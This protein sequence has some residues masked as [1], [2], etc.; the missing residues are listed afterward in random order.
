M[1]R[2][3]SLG[4]VVAERICDLRR[5]GRR[6]GRVTV[7]LGRPVRAPDAGPQDP[8]WCIVRLSG[9]G[10]E[11]ERPIAG[12]DSLQAL[13]LALEFA[14]DILPHEA[15]GLG[16]R[17]DWLAQPERLVLAKQGMAA[18]DGSGFIAL[19]DQISDKPA[20]A[21]TPVT[22]SAQPASPPTN[23]GSRPARRLHAVAAT[24]SSPPDGPRPPS[25][26]PR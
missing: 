24:D 3:Q 18:A 5:G 4:E 12:A 14:A 21:L 26:R 17:L 11:L 8:W 25:R 2:P 20:N 6:V 13:L 9:T 7:S 22:A 1:W 23:K 16:A 10:I 19:L 15:E